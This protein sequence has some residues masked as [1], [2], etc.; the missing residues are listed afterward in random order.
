[1]NNPKHINIFDFDDTMFRTQNFASL[2]PKGK[3]MYEWYDSERS[4][5]PDFHIPTIE[6]VVEKTRLNGNPNY[7]ITH[8]KL[9]NKEQVLRLLSEQGC[10][11]TEV[12]FCERDGDK[13]DVLKQILS[14]NPTIESVTIYEDSISELTKYAAVLSGSKLQVT[15]FF[16]DKTKIFELPLPAIEIIRHL[17][18]PERIR[19][20]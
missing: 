6:N 4:L 17:G 1:M 11:F 2:E 10:N 13:A 9:V 18:K 12:F 16:V 7:L 15:I 3:T 20:T 5:S 19:L 14:E 8:R